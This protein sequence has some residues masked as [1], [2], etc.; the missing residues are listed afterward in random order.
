MEAPS[1]KFERASAY[2]LSRNFILFKRILSVISSLRLPL[3]VCFLLFTFFISSAPL[4]S[5]LLTLTPRRFAPLYFS[6]SRRERE[7]VFNAK[8][9]H[10]KSCGQSLFFDDVKAKVHGIR[11]F[12]NVIS[13][14][15][16]R[17]K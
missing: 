10:W 9:C 1:E 8:R 13:I 15:I 11:S 7:R 3:Y 16:C 6:S 4:V 17:S 5:T 12:S 14:F 2:Q